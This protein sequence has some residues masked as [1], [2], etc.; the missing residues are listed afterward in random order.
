MIITTEFVAACETE[1]S[2]LQMPWCWHHSER[3][4]MYIL[5]IM[6]AKYGNALTAQYL[7][8]S[9]EFFIVEEALS[10][11]CLNLGLVVLHSMYTYV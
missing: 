9:N 6:N 8:P 2:Y 7:E 3:R 10:S 5:E 1:R 11:M 4:D